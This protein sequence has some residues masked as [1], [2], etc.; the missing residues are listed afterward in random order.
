MVYPG[1][2]FEIGKDGLSCRVKAIFEDRVTVEC[3]NDYQLQEKQ[4]IQI[5]GAKMGLNN[6][7]MQI[8]EHFA[9]LCSKYPVDKIGLCNVN[10]SKVVK[11]CSD[12]IQSIGVNIQIV[13][14]ID[15]QEGLKNYEEIL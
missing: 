6:D 5:K 13:S 1:L 3:L 10:N 7:H 15:S 14:K 9:T 11:D 8:Y 4:E 12:F 2:V